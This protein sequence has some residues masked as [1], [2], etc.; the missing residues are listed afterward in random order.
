M[1]LQMYRD[2]CV[3]VEFIT[4]FILYLV[5]FAKKCNERGV[6]VHMHI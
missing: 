4:Y 5:V 2:C 1:Q 3:D 6:K